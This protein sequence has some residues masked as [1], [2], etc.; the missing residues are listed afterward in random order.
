MA[1]TTMM[2]DAR[3]IGT[4]R[5]RCKDSKAP[6]TF[7]I[8]KP[9]GVE[10]EDYS[11]G[12]GQPALVYSSLCDLFFCSTSF[13]ILD[14]NKIQNLF[15]IKLNSDRNLT[16]RWEWQQILDSQDKIPLGNIISGKSQQEKT[17]PPNVG[18]G[19]VPVN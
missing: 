8:K 2:E 16:R 15:S 3:V 7:D 6:W 13:L 11:C 12:S 14:V 18:L 19:E 4:W 1:P 5:S 9:R 17:P 10:G